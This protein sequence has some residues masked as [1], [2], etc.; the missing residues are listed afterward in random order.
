LGSI[1]P[2]RYYRGNFEARIKNKSTLKPEN[3]DFHEGGEAN[4]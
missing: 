4:I 2:R 3:F 1:M